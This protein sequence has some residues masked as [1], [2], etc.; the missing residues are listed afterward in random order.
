M[1][2]VIKWPMMNSINMLSLFLLLLSL[3][4]VNAQD[5]C[6][7]QSNIKVVSLSAPVTYMLEQLDLLHS[8]QLV[9][10][11]NYHQLQQDYKHLKRLPGGEF[12]S[13]QIV[14][15]W[16]DHI[17]LYD[18]SQRLSQILARNPRIHLIEVVTRDLNWEQS[19]ERVWSK[20][21]PYLNSACTTLLQNT[22]LKMINK[23][24]QIKTLRSKPLAAVFFVGNCSQDPLPKLVMLQ[25]GVLKDLIASGIIQT[26]KS[27]LA[28]LLWSERDLAEFKREHTPIYICLNS[29]PD[30]A[31]KKSSLNQTW[32]FYHPHILNPG[33]PQLEA[34]LNLFEQLK[35]NNL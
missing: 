11:S 12:I 20:L 2:I 34:F 13:Q 16:S 10:V 33:F 6:Q 18:Q 30:M 15:Q 14:D 19:F 4:S 7:F 32:N 31:L 24:E 8:P 28:Y 35:I 1:S 9:A 25:D 27:P 22:R 5:K 3:Q 29:S 23:M 17:L 21:R 26:L